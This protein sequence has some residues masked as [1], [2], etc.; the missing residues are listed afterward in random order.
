MTIE[1]FKL[2]YYII[3]SFFLILLNLTQDFI[4]IILLYIYYQNN[5]KDY[6]LFFCLYSN[7]LTSI[8]CIL[9]F[10]YINY[11]ENI[12]DKIKIILKV[13]PITTIINLLFIVFSNSINLY[14]WDIY[15]GVYIGDVCWSCIIVP[16]YC[17]LL[18][19]ELIIVNREN[20]EREINE[21]N[22]RI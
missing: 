15:I 1:N 17:C 5:Y 21:M 4:C 10:I 13:F 8:T 3:A 2:L 11:W 6:M 19:L 14:I 12:D 7:I 9:Y 18:R 22:L 16:V 20:L